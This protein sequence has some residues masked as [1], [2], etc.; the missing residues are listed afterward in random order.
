MI[1]IVNLGLANV[2]SVQRA[3]GRQGVPC[4]L[5]D[6]PAF[7]ACTHLVFPGVGHFARAAELLTAPW[8]S[9][10]MKWI[11]SGR[12]FLGICLGYQLLHEGSDEAPGAKG[13]GVLGGTCRRVPSQRV[14]HMGW[15]R[16]KASEPRGRGLDGQ[17]MYFTHS[18]APPA[19]GA[20]W[21][22]EDG[23]GDFGVGSAKASVVGVQFHPEKSAEAGSTL[24]Q[25][26]WQG[27]L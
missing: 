6:T 15:N 13:L 5:V 27:S 25:S 26:F 18:Y 12:P 24:L 21:T 23:G 11:A 2:G 14:P 7:G 4:M 20:L 9:G 3:F 1:G 17:F 22:A 16:L 19:E 10:L 8:R